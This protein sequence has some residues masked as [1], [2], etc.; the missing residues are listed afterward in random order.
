MGKQDEHFVLLMQ[1][2]KVFHY[3][4]RNLKK[5]SVNVCVEDMDMHT[6]THTC[7]GQ[8]AMLGVFLYHYLPYVLS[9]NLS[10][11]LEL[12]NCPDWLAI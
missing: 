1:A 2:I 7:G 12:T 3:M 4:M 5:K 8:R 6:G 10:L 11:S 9:Q